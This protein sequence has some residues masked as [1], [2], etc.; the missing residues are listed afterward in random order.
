MIPIN[1]KVHDITREE[2]FEDG[3]KYYARLVGRISPMRDTRD[4]A[5]L[6]KE[7]ED[8]LTT[9]VPSAYPN[10]ILHQEPI[11]PNTKLDDEFWDKFLRRRGQ[12][13]KSSVSET[14][15][16]IPVIKN[17]IF[18][19]P[20][21]IVFWSDGSK[22]VVKCQ[23]GDV[24]DPEKGLAM[25]IVKKSLGNKGN[26]CN[27]LKPWVVVDDSRAKRLE[28]KRRDRCEQAYQLLVNNANDPKATKKDLL[29]AMD[30][31]IGYLGEVL[32]D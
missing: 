6:R 25:A 15:S 7:L 13:S 21:T 24:Y 10:I 12:V 19:A 16:Y 31:A 4:V 28:E 27:Q 18:N 23:D 9:D 1:W 8:R 32:D 22:T 11:I 5:R 2:T 20:A 29:I 3:V 17:V 30:E 26:Y 14:K